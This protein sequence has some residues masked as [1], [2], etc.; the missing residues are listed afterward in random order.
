M[1]AAI[2]DTFNALR[3]VEAAQERGEGP[4]RSYRWTSVYEANGEEAVP[5]PAGWFAGPRDER[6]GYWRFCP[7]RP[8]GL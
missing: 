5:L 4:Q 7:S 3:E 6:Y 8:V 2:D 1:D